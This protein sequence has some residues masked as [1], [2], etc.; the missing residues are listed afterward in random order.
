[1]AIAKH[2]GVKA[3]DVQVSSGPKTFDGVILETPQGRMAIVEFKGHGAKLNYRQAKTLNGERNPDRLVQQGTEENIR[4]VIDDMEASDPIMARRLRD[5]L[6]EGTL[7]FYEAR[8][9][10]KKQGGNVV[11]VNPTKIRKA[12]LRK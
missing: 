8:T 11:D 10:F 2:L 1:M 4:G 9:G 12:K 7:D 3:A 5:S 6:R